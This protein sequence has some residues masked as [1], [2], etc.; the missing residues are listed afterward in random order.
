MGIARRDVP[1]EDRCRY[2]GIEDEIKLLVPICRD[3]AVVTAFRPSVF[4]IMFVSRPESPTADY[5]RY[6]RIEGKIILL[7]PVRRNPSEET[8]FRPS[9]FLIVLVP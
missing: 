8:P 3:A 2:I 7:V 4:Q 9:V 6:V 5:R 1:S